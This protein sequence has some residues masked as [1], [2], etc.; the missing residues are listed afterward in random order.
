MRPVGPHRVRLRTAVLTG[1][2]LVAAVAGCVF[3]AVGTVAA[4][5]SRA[6]AAAGPVTAARAVVGTAAGA[7]VIDPADRPAAPTL[8]GDD[9]DGKPVGL[10]GLRGNVVV[11]NVWGS[12]CGPCRAEADD[13]ARI[14][15]QTRDQGVRFLGINTRDPDRAAARSFVRAHDIGFPSLHDPT[16]E[17]LLRF[18]PALL[19]PQAIPSTLVIDRRGRIAVSIGG[20]VTGDELGP[21][22]SR[23]T[24]EAP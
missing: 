22:L 23:V 11:L 10:D 6:E 17:L 16:G 12:W 5:G 3:A 19:N 1:A 20:P 9:L 14:D 18:P 24:E 7:T 13:L 8:A 21:L 15:R 2:A 4:D